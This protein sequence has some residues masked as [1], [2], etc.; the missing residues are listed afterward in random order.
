MRSTARVLV[1]LVAFGVVTALFSSSGRD[2]RAQQSGTTQASS[3]AAAQVGAMTFVTSQDTWTTILSSSIKTPNQKDL[4]IS[5]SLVSSLFTSTTVNSKNGATDTQSATAGVEVRVLL[6]GNP[7]PPGIV[8]F[9]KRI[10]TLSATL[11]GIIS[12]AL[13]TDASGNIIIDPTLVTNEQITLILQTMSANAFNFVQGNVSSGMH[14]VQ[15]QVK[16]NTSS[17]TT[18]SASALVGPGSFTV[19]EVRLVQGAEIDLP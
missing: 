15:V 18:A 3:K 7:V 5:V 1:G 19:E 10:Q 8:V 16:V 2:L 17:T 6:D 9:A 14:R 12:G 11:Q 4:F 13:T